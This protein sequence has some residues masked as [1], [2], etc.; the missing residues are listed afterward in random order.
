MLVLAGDGQEVFAGQGCD[1]DVV[2][3][4]RDSGQG[5]FGT[6]LPEDL[7]GL[8]GNPQDRHRGQEFADGT[9]FLFAL[10]TV[11]SAVV[12]LTQYD[13]RQVEGFGCFEFLGDSLDPTE[14]PDHDVRIQEHRTNGHRLARRC[15]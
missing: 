5:E 6:D 4:D 3:R 7:G 8:R 1:P 2:G 11:E 14:V 15:L 12:K 10:R 13:G 9:K